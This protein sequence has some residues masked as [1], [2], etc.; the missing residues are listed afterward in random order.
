MVFSFVKQLDQLTYNVVL[1]C[2][3][4]KKTHG[5]IADQI[6]KKKRNTFLD[7]HSLCITLRLRKVNMNLKYRH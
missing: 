3:S 4:N 6:L 1:I 7:N 2:F 5:L